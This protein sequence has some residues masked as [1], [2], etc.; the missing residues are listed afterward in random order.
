MRMGRTGETAAELI[1]RLSEAELADVLREFG[2]EPFARPI[3]RALKAGAPADHPGGR[4]VDQARRAAEGLALKRPRGH[5]DLPGAAHRRERRARASWSGSSRSLPG[6]FAS[7]GGRRS[8]PSTASRTAG[9][10][11]LPHPRGPL[12]LP[13]R[14]SGLRLRRAGAAGGSSPEGGA[15]LGRRGG[16]RNPRAR[17]ARLRAV[18]RVA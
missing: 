18:E 9:E 17:S 7:A 6:C 14:A 8:S 13:A 15:G 4:R 11:G 1:A 10:A 12:H 16:Q 3:A 2:E 5:P